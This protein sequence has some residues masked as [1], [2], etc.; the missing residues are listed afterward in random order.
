MNIEQSIKH[1]SERLP[2]VLRKETY[3][4]DD[5]ELVEYYDDLTGAFYS[6]T[7]T[8]FNGIKVCTVVNSGIS[9]DVPMLQV[10]DHASM[11]QHINDLQRLD[12]FLSVVCKGYHK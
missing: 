2:G 10:A 12:Q 3:A 5:M 8:M 6:G 9:V 11:Q 4:L 7:V 1:S